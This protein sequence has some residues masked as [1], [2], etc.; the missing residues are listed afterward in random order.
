MSASEPWQQAVVAE[1]RRRRAA[2]K[3][4]AKMS[5]PLIS[6][7]TSEADVL[8][9]M[10]VLMSNQLTMGPQVA[11]F[12]AAFAKWVCAPYACMVNSGSSANLLAI[13]ALAN[14][15]RKVHLT[16]GDEV[17]VPAVCWSTSVYPLMQYNLVPVFVDCDPSTMNVDLVDMKRR[18]TKQTRGV[19]LVHVLGNSCPME[20]CIDLCKEHGLIIFEDTCE[21]LGS[22]VTIHGASPKYL[23]TIGDMGS[24]SFYYSHH[25]TTGEGGMVVCNTLEDYNLLRCLRAHGWSRHRLD[26]KECDARNPDID[27]RFNFVNVGYNLR[28]LEVTAAMGLVQLADLPRANQ[29]RRDNFQRLSAAILQDPR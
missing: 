5:F 4:A 24:Y 7:T 26:V 15:E 12:E 1:W 20:A 27:P 23:G 10:E 8:A 22:S 6:N 25:M 17:L 21:S 13:A 11:A 29:Q 16:P 2:E 3:T 14:P 28:P 9:M 18:I 19:V